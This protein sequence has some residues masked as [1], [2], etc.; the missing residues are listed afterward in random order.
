MMH[1]IFANFPEI[2]VFARKIYKNNKNNLFLDDIKKLYRGNKKSEQISMSLDE[3]K[4]EILKIGIK[5]GDILL[6]HSSVGG[7]EMISA[8]PK[9]I[10][11]TL[12]GILGDSG[13]LVMP[14]FP[15]YKNYESEENGI[16]KYNPQKTLAW[17]GILPNVFLAMQGTYRSTYPNNSLAA[18]GRFA[19]KMFENEMKDERSHGENSAWNFCAE[20]H[21]KVL[22]LGVNPNHSLSE[23]HLGED[24]MGD[25]WPI[26][27]W[28][29]RQKYLIHING[30]SFEKECQVRK[31]FWTQY[32]TEEYC[33]RKLIKDGLLKCSSGVCKG[34][35]ADM[36]EL[37]MWLLKEIGKGN[38]VFYRIPKKFWKREK[39]NNEINE[40]IR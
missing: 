10:I 23:I 16:L 12:L 33:I 19:E 6:V 27:N 31:E 3:F 18:N 24:L 36:K 29:Y 30:E 5:R 13:T 7:M 26:E 21:A 34:Y 9:Q 2:E 1:K 25:E 39:V 15:Y 35:I 11:N 37:K 4:M 20:H 8:T 22:F 40:N 14:A 17:T 28:C 38:L 32:L